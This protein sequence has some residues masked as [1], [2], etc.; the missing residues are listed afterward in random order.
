MSEEKSLVVV[1]WIVH[2]CDA[3]WS[4]GTQYIFNGVMEQFINN[5]ITVGWML[6]TNLDEIT[7]RN[8]NY[9]QRYYLPKPERNH[10]PPFPPSM[11]VLKGRLTRDFG[12]DFQVQG[13]WALVFH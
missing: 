12:R 6:S 10:P 2:P 9:I 11:Y 4:Q 5:C 1:P 8:V 3:L 7:P 13:A